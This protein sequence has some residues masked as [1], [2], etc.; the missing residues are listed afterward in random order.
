MYGAWLKDRHAP[1]LFQFRRME[2][3]FSGAKRCFQ[4][5]EGMDKN[6][7][8]RGDGYAA[9]RR[10]ISPLHYSSNIHLMARSARQIL[11]FPY[12]KT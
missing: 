7:G 8:S 11:P 3:A 9:G 5:C 12:H 6:Y 10:S 1:T 4:P 2:A